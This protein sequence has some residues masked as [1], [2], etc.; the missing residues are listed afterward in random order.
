VP[1]VSISEIVMA[2][3]SS[4]SGFGK[5]EVHRLWT[6]RLQGET[7]SLS[8]ARGWVLGA[9]LALLAFLFAGVAM[10]LASG[11]APS[12]PFVL[13]GAAVLLLAVAAA[14]LALASLWGAL[15]TLRVTLRQG[16]ALRLDPSRIVLRTRSGDVVLPWDDVTL[17]FGKFFLKIR[18]PR[19]RS[20][21][22]QPAAPME[23]L[24][25]TLLVSGGATELRE[26]IRRVRP[27]KLGGAG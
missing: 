7:V 9:L 18:A 19:P 4:T 20:A 3:E 21:A 16:P 23:V 2:F 10:L 22:G 27:E 1:V 24:I 6:Q 11:A 8:P 14:A 15:R 12:L 17:S 25:P 5:R 26:A 13:P